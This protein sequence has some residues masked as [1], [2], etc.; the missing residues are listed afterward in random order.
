MTT[1]FEKSP[2]DLVSPYTVSWAR[3]M[4]DLNTTIASSTWAVI[5]GDVTIA[6]NSKTDT[7]TTVVVS[8]GKGKSQLRNTIVTAAG[9][10]LEETVVMDVRQH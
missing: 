4:T 9:T 2:G 1:H 10:T 7:T 6:S 8:A 3:E 5:E